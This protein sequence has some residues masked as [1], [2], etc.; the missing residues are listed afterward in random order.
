VKTV[1]GIIAR[2]ESQKEELFSINSSVRKATFILSWRGGSPGDS[3]TFDLTA[4]NNITIPVQMQTI[5]T[6]SFYRIATIK[7][8][9]DIRRNRIEHAGT[10]KLVIKPALSADNVR[11]ALI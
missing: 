6:G 7:L 1:S 5:K 11:T 8:P 2:T 3:L 9:L 4:P 10:W